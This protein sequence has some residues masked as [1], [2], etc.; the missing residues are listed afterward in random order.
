ML[1]SLAMRG[2]LA[3]MN[4]MLEFCSAAQI[5]VAASKHIQIHQ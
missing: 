3:G 4:F 1:V 5:S 2:E